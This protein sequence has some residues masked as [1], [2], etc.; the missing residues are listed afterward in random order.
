MTD[1]DKTAD[2]N[3]AEKAFLMSDINIYIEVKTWL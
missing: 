3:N 2:M 1:K